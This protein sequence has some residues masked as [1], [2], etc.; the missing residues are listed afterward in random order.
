[1]RKILGLLLALLASPAVAQVSSTQ[2]PTYVGSLTIATLPLTGGEQIYLLQNSASRRTAV[3]NLY[4]MANQGTLCNSALLNTYQQFVN[5]SSAPGSVSFTYWDGLQCV[6]WGSLNATAH[7]MS[8]FGPVLVGGSAV[9]STLTL[10]STLAT[11]TSDAILFLTGAQVQRGKVQTDGSFIWTSGTS[12]INVA[13]YDQVTNSGKAAW[14]VTN[15]D[16][17]AL[18]ALEHYTAWFNAWTNGTGD[19][20]VPASTFVIGVSAIKN[21]WQTT[22]TPGEYGGINVVCRG[23]HNNA[24]VSGDTDCY[25]ANY[26]VSQTNNFSAAYEGIGGYFPGG[27]TNN[28][29]VI[30]TQIGPVRATGLDIAADTGIGYFTQARNGTSGFAFQASNTCAVPQYNLCGK[31]GLGGFN[32]A[33]DDGVHTA[34]NAFTVGP[35]G[36]LTMGGAA[37]GGQITLNGITSGNRVLTVNA[38]A[39]AFTFGGGALTVAEGGTGDTGTAWTA[40]TPAYSCGTATFTNGSS[41]SKTLGKTTWIEVDFT[42]TAIGTCASPNVTFTLPNTA[43]SSGNAA[44]GQEVAVTANTGLCRVAAASATATCAM[45]GGPNWLVNEHYVGSG[46]YENQ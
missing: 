19:G 26:G 41:R 9:S 38:T 42:I 1:M 35:Q 45:Q 17:S 21:N 7:T 8:F 36:Q 43:N 11:G 14:Q 22:T 16:N 44:A 15:T 28:S 40:F 29:I 24:L 27:S 3:S 2:F 25:Q 6:P 13:T 33:L 4:G 32:Y 20:S 18:S 46:V 12:S 5:T 30:N 10:E 39:T 37:L 34:Y 23:G 31:W